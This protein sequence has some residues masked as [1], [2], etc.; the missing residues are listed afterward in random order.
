MPLKKITKPEIIAISLNVFRKN[1]YHHTAMSD[2][3]EAC[4]LQ[5]GSFYHYFESK[6]VLMLAVLENVELLLQNEVF[7]LAYTQGL[8]PRERMDAL[9]RKFSKELLMQEGGCIV[10]NM[11]LET[12]LSIE[13]FRAIIQKIFDGWQAA[14]KHIFAEKFSEEVSQKM[15]EQTIMEFEGAVMLQKIYHSDKYLRD[16]YLRVMSKL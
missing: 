16:C 14:L 4:G 9:I 1:G 6:E 15:A 11:T 10:G 3:A 2:L 7:P 8:A 13:A 5:K 12:A